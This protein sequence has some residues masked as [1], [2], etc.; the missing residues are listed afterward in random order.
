MNDQQLGRFAQ[1]VEVVQ[2]QQFKEIVRQG[3]HGDAMYLIL[4]G[5]VRVRQIIGGKETTI[6]TLGPGEFFGEISL[7]DQGPRSADVVANTDGTLLKIT[8]AVFED[9]A[10]KEPDLATPFMLAVARTL[11][12]RIR[13]DNKR[14]RDSLS[15]AR[16]AGV[17]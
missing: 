17:K 14:Y 1:I 6:A 15:F 9:L 3:E 2:L 10:Q 11:T 7:F 5:E 16:A 4:E 8:V 12:A 13:A